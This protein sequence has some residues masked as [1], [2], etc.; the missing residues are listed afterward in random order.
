ML[1]LCSINVQILF[2]IEKLV[3]SALHRVKLLD[4]ASEKRYTKIL[5]LVMIYYPQLIINNVM[6]SIKSESNTHSE[7]SKKR[8]F[9]YAGENTLVTS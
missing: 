6:K 9:E 1:K 7:K 5:P 4:P 2:R 3:K 8:K